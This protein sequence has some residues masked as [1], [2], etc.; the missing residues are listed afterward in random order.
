LLCCAAACTFLKHAQQGHFAKVV[1]CLTPLG[2]AMLITMSRVAA[3][4]H[5]FA[6][7]NAGFIIGMLS[8]FLGVLHQL[9]VVQ[10]MV[11]STAQMTTYPHTY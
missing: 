7:V 10:C 2:V 6:D 1:L 9:S 11:C 8:G 3:Y 5:D 4:K